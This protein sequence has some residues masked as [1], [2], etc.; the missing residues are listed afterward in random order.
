[1]KI[2]FVSSGNSKD[3]ISPIIN[4]QGL[5]LRRQGYEIDFFT[6]NGKG[7]SA[8]FKHIFLLRK[9]ITKSNYDIIHAHYGLCGLVGLLARKSEKLVVSFMGDDIVGTNKPDGSVYF[10]SI[11][12][13]RFNVFLSHYFYDHSIV[14]SDEMMDKM[15]VQKRVSLI[16]NG[17]DLNK[18]KPLSR[19]T[20]ISNTEINPQKK[21]IIFVS[22]PSR[23]EKNFPLARKAHDLLDDPMVELLVLSD[24]SNDLLKYY[25]NAADVLL[26]TSFHEGSPNVIKE[27]MACNCPIVTTNVGDVKWVI[28]NTEGCYITGFESEDVAEKLNKVLELGK[29]TN[30]RDR[31]LE[32]GLDSETVANKIIEIYSKVLN[33]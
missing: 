5:S 9:I 4:N 16:S 24:I 13:S 12:F 10:L 8:Y 28:G 7:F 20:A 1:M 23:A 17:V 32:L 33:Q 14:K 19:E 11:I 3:G 21:C 2:L 30:G 18:F 25:Y 26:L 6:I 22:Q 15:G 27:A 31:I 29:K